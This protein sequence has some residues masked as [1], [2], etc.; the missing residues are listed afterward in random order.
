MSEL[1][2]VGVKDEKDFILRLWS[3]DN[4][5]IHVL[6]SRTYADLFHLSKQTPSPPSATEP[7]QFPSSHCKKLLKFGD[8]DLVTNWNP[9]LTKSLKILNDWLKNLMKFS[10]LECHKFY[11]ELLYSQESFKRKER[12]ALESSARV[13]Q[14]YFMSDENMDTMVTETLRFYLPNCL[15]I[16]PSCGDGR[17]LRALMKRLSQMPLEERGHRQE[18]GELGTNVCG[19]DID[20]NILERCLQPH[21]TNGESKGESNDSSPLKDRIHLGNFLETTSDTFISMISPPLS[22][23]SCD[24]VWWSTLHMWRR[25]WSVISIRRLLN[26]HWKRLPSSVHCSLSRYT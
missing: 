16:E 10:P 13:L 3:Q 18:E 5:M 19:C 11:D 14:Q 15:F 20:P 1:E 25:H 12:K 8:W 17:L 2:I 22:S 21:G 4:P 23:F 6:I 7:L 24:S 26:R 9:Y